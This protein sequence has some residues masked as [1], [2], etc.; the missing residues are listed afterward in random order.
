MLLGGTIVMVQETYSLTRIMENLPVF[1][2][3][4][5]FGAREGDVAFVRKRGSDGCKLSARGGSWA[6]ACRW[7][8]WRQP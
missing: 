1:F 4:K 3:G 2:F 8:M 5:P 7:M 6:T